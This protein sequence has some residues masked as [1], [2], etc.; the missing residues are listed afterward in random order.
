CFSTLVIANTDSVVDLADKNLS[1]A[2]AAGAGGANDGLDC[3]LLHLVWN[4]HLNLYLGEKIDGI[5]PPAVELC[6]SLL[7]AVAAGLQDRHAFDAC[8]QQRI[9]Y[10]IQLRRLENRFDLDHVYSASV[11]SLSGRAGW[12]A[13]PAL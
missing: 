11:D 3:L 6:V 10:R 5:F 13:T 2:D 1:V 8:L 7:P 9:L 12:L 4:H